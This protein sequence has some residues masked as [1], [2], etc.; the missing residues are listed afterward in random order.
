[1]TEKLFLLR[2]QSDNEERPE[3]F[4]HSTS[5]SLSGIGGNGQQ[6]S[7]KLPLT[8]MLFISFR[9]EYFWVWRWFILF[10]R[11]FEI[12]NKESGLLWAS[13][14]VSSTDSCCRPR[15]HIFPTASS[16]ASCWCPT[17]KRR[18]VFARLAASSPELALCAIKKHSELVLLW[19]GVLNQ[20]QPILLGLDSI[21]TQA[22]SH[23]NCSKESCK[24]IR[25]CS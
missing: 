1:M 6:V 18:S 10:L 3:A 24:C 20:A 21:R 17:G 25:T 15:T 12:I 8:G 5:T 23:L 9:K 19:A 13:S 2:K 14:S 22:V 16:A 4:K 11:Y 7:G